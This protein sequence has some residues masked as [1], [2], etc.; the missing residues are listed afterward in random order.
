[1]YIAICYT[2]YNLNFI[3]Y[4]CYVF[5]GRNSR[6]RA[7]TCGGLWGGSWVYIRRV[8]ESL[9]TCVHRQTLQD[10]HEH[11]NS[12]YLRSVV[13]WQTLDVF[14]LFGIFQSFY[15]DQRANFLKIK[16]NKVKVCLFT[17]KGAIVSG[18]GTLRCQAG[19]CSTN[20]PI[21]YVS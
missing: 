11:K 8:N 14:V 19:I 5:G 1:M 2:E 20:Y 12:R 7:S 17:A 4:L 6:E 9:H 16:K 18:K 15:N 21:R 10:V 3:G 13:L